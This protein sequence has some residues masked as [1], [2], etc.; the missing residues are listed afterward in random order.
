V[1]DYDQTHQ[2]LS[3]QVAVAKAPPIKVRINQQIGIKYYLIQRKFIDKT[4][5]P[6]HGIRVPRN[7]EAYYS[8]MQKNIS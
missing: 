6:L 1:Q 7:G 5:M 3:G 2:A 4:K 8:E